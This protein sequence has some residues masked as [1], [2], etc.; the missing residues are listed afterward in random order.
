MRRM[1]LEGRVFRCA[2]HCDDETDSG[3]KKCGGNFATKQSVYGA[4]ARCCAKAW[5]KVD[6]AGWP[7]TIMVEEA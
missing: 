3:Q 1:Q 5:A 7:V 6:V 2:Y 4:V